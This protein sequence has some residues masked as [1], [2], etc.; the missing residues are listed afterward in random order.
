LSRLNKVML[1]AVSLSESSDSLRF[2]QTYA[3]AIGAGERGVATEILIAAEN[4]WQARLPQG[5]PLAAR[6]CRRDWL[7]VE[8]TGIA[9]HE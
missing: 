1:A 6:C 8:R 4:S 5:S 3:A 7:L 9:S 2:L